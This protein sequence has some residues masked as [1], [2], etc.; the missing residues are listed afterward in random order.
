MFSAAANHGRLKWC[1]CLVLARGT[2]D[3]TTG[4][5]SALESR[6]RRSLADHGRFAAVEAERFAGVI[7]PPN[8]LL[9]SLFLLR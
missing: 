3:Q 5:R 9:R 2:V 7:F 8:L 4:E 1:F 6:V